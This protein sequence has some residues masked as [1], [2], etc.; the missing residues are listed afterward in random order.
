MNLG[1]FITKIKRFVKIN[2]KKVSILLDKCRE[3]AAERCSD[4]GK[5]QSPEGQ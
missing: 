2:E 5:L 4:Y 1:D 3:S